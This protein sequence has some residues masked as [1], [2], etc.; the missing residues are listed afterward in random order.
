MGNSTSTCTH[1]RLK[2]IPVLTG[3][4]F[5]GY[6]YGYLQV[7]WVPK[8]GWVWTTGCTC[9]DT[10]QRGQPSLSRQFTLV[11]AAGRVSPS[12]SCRFAFFDI[13]GRERPS[14]SRQ[15]VSTH[16]CVCDGVLNGGGEQ[17]GRG[18][19]GLELDYHVVFNLKTYLLWG[20]A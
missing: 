19:R 9:I 2:P 7:A 15:F 11:N 4:G 17:L 8:P 13:A 3:T 18:G 12:L 14:P 20:W 10:A 16:V 6:G 1:T 5:D